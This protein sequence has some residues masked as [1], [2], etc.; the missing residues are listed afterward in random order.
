MNISPSNKNGVLFC[1]M[2]TMPLLEKHNIL[3]RVAGHGP[4]TD[5]NL[6]LRTA[7]PA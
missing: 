6:G 2:I 5:K 7:G 4:D 3:T 1:R